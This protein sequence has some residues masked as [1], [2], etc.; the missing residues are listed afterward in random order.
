M[1]SIF[2]IEIT[3]FY[4]WNYDFFSMNVWMSPFVFF[5][6]WIAVELNAMLLARLILLKSLKFG[7]TFD[8]KF[9]L[10]SKPYVWLVRIGWCSEPKLCDVFWNAVYGCCLR[11]ISGVSPVFSAVNGFFT[12][13]LITPTGSYWYG[14]RMLLKKLSTN[15]DFI[16]GI[17]RGE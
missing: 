14:C 12:P 10:S 6:Q 17:G 7:F 15:E 9:G 5:Y 13:L 16:S 4:S 11:Y 1:E 8:R 2:C 3:N